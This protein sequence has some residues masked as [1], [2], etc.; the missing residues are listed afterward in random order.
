MPPTTAKPY[1]DKDDTLSK[2][3]TM[4]LEERVGKPSE[5]QCLLPVPSSGTAGTENP[6]TRYWGTRSGTC[7]G[8]GRMRAAPCDLSAMGFGQHPAS[9]KVRNF[10]SLPSPLAAPFQAH[11][12]CRSGLSLSPCP[13][14]AIHRDLPRAP[15][16]PQMPR[17]PRR[18]LLLDQVF[19]WQ[20]LSSPALSTALCCAS[21][22][23]EKALGWWLSWITPELLSKVTHA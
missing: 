11:T 1:S 21:A 3:I 22:L 4:I 16:S 5:G 18:S 10:G 14:P 20:P 2:A 15:C 23:Q 7:R 6:G 13:G 19:P 12:S 8:G 9:D 17:S